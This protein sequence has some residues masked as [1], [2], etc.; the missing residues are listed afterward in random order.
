MN[1]K[2]HEFHC[3]ISYQTGAIERLLRVIRVR[4]FVI[5]QL[6]LEHVGN[7]YSLKLTIS[8][9]RSPDNLLWQLKK[10]VEVRQVSYQ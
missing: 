6:S 9:Q 8:G 5:K 7:H 4:G 10:L 3:Q 1:P 2:H